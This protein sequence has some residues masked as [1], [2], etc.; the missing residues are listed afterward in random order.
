MKR[1][2]FQAYLETNVKESA[3]NSVPHRGRF[4]KMAPLKK[5]KSMVIGSDS[6]L[7]CLNRQSNNISNLENSLSFFLLVKT[8]K[9][10]HNLFRLSIATM[11]K[12]FSS[13]WDTEL[14]LFKIFVDIFGFLPHFFRRWLVHLKR[15][16]KSNKDLYQSKNIVSISNY[17]SFI[18]QYQY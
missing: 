8:L 14:N 7:W 2:E 10:S 4:K 17:L 18:I 9:K 1:T 11:I 12:H 15:F 3:S 6:C 5:E 16:M 13:C